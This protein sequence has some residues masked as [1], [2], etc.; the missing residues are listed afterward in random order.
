MRHIMVDQL[1][2]EAIHAERRIIDA[3]FGCAQARR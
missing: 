2:D 1:S 3:A